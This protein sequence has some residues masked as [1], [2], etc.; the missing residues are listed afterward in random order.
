MLWFCR[1]LFILT[2][3]CY[4]APAF[5]HAGGDEVYLWRYQFLKGD[6]T[7]IKSRIRVECQISDRTV[8]TVIDTVT[9]DRTQ[10]VNARGDAEMLETIDTFESS[11]NGRQIPDDVKSHTI[12]AITM[13]RR[14][15]VLQGNPRGTPDPYR[16]RALWQMMMERPAPDT[17]IKIGETWRSDVTNCFV[18]GEKTSVVS[19]LIKAEKVSGIDTLRIGV[20]MSIQPDAA[21]DDKEYVTVV[22]YYNVDPL[23]GRLVH[24]EYTLSNVP[25]RGQ[26]G[27][28]VMCITIKDDREPVSRTSIL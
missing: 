28:G 20:R 5:A 11:Y 21:A 4:C 12:L 22:G 10:S 27:N 26:D 13:D 15:Q 24:S 6:L 1:L 7:R 19:K 8:A 3:S 23:A 9:L 17:A 25:V 2:P 16:I 14:G 18:Q